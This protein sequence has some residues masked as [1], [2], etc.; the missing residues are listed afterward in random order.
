MCT[1]PNGMRRA[2]R[3]DR[4]NESLVERYSGNLGGVHAV[5][6]R[7]PCDGWARDRGGSTASERPAQSPR[8]RLHAGCRSTGSQVLTCVAPASA[9]AWWG[10][11]IQSVGRPSG[12]RASRSD[13][14]RACLSCSKPPG[15]PSDRWCPGGRGRR[16]SDSPRGS[17]RTSSA[18]RTCSRARDV[19]RSHRSEAASYASHLRSGA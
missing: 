1:A 14:I 7:K 15:S 19:L 16:C 12:G 4:A 11:Q 18:L 17:T 10:A 3:R 2:F 5:V 6:S 13:R 9:Q 8:N